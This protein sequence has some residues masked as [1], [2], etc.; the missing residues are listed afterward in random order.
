M[1]FTS[2]GQVVILV[3]RQL[4]EQSGYD[5]LGVGK[6]LEISSPHSP[7]FVPVFVAFTEPKEVDL[8]SLGQ[9]VLWPRTLLAVYGEKGLHSSNPPVPASPVSTISTVSSEDRQMNYGLQVI[10]LGVM[11]LQLHDTEAEGNG[12]R[13]LRNWKLLMLYFRL[14]SRG[15]KY[16]FD[17]MRFITFIKALYSERMAHRVLHVQFVNPRGG[18]AKTM[19]LT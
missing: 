16:A 7:D 2:L 14:C 18:K 4:E 17:A 9:V 5:I 8:L 19:L 6:V 11:L 10:Q 15:M 12:E 1:I 13:S 3:Q